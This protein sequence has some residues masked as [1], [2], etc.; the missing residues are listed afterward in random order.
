[1]ELQI[2]Y[3][4]FALADG[5]GEFWAETEIGTLAPVADALSRSA[6]LD[7]GE[8]STPRSQTMDEWASRLPKRS[9]FAWS[10]RVFGQLGQASSPFDELSVELFDELGAAAINLVPTGGNDMPSTSTAN[11]PR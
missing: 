8:P 5:E 7:Q 2:N 11:S 4:N 10:D 6:A 1:M 9:D 3:L